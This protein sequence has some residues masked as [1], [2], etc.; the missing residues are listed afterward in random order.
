MSLL[1]RAAF[2]VVISITIVFVIFFW[3]A[4]DAKS[5]NNLHIYFLDVGQGDSTFIKTPQDKYVLIDGGE[6]SLVVSELSIFSS[7]MKKNIDLAILSHPHEDHLGGFLHLK[8][9]FSFDKVIQMPLDHTSDTYIQ[10]LEY[11]KSENIPVNSVVADDLI[12][13]EQDI[14]FRVLWPESEDGLGEYSLNNTSVVL[15][16]KFK[17]FRALLMGDAEALVEEQIVNSQDSLEANVLKVGHHGSITSS[18]EN[19][20]N[21]VLPQIAVISV[22]K[23]NKF[24]HPSEDVIERL[25]EKG[26]EIYRTDEFGTVEVITNGERFW[27]EE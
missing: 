5:D 6:G 23:D 18:S 21:S 10:W 9:Y 25:M 20:V 26:I 1:K 17:D 13:V 24:G 3:S 27:I 16:L 2:K 15:M 19:F 7:P 11:L 22:G 14:S 4:L 12:E 8:D